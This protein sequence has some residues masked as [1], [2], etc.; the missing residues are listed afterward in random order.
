[1]NFA[2]PAAGTDT[3]YTCRHH[4]IGPCPG[5]R[6][7]TGGR[8][9]WWAGPGVG[10]ASAG[11]ANGRARRGGR[12]QTCAEGTDRRGEEG[13]APASGPGERARSRGGPG[14]GRRTGGGEGWGR[15]LARPEPDPQSPRAEPPDTCG[16]SARWTARPPGAAGLPARRC[17]PGSRLPSRPPGLRGL[18]SC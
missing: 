15:P 10:G 6:R 9:Q 2:S 17:L 3:S 4:V 11:G 8:G 12:E 1:M 18:I 14:Y 13:G 7:R 16:P 5:R